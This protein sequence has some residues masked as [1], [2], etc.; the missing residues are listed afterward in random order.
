MFRYISQIFSLNSNSTVPSLINAQK[1]RLFIQR[2]KKFMLFNFLLFSPHKLFMG[3]RGGLASSPLHRKLGIVRI[4]WH[5]YK[6][7]C[8]P[9][10]VSTCILEWCKGH[11]CF[12]WQQLV[13][14]MHEITFLSHLAHFLSHLALF[15]SWGGSYSVS[16]GR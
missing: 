7:N 3:R 13:F 6:L 8:R 4:K 1:F 11:N 16:R 10:L 2:F 9:I 12:S 5:F 14:P 15:L